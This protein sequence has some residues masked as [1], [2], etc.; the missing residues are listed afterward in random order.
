MAGSVA[1]AFDILARDRASSEINKVA[2]SFGHAAKAGAFLG[3]VAGSVVSKGL[4]LLGSAAQAAFAQVGSTISA[5]S[6]Y[7]ESLSKTRAVFGAASGSIEAFAKTT[8][9]GLGISQQE[10]LEAASTFGNLFTAMKIGVEPSAEMSK[11][12]VTLAGDLASFNNVGTDEA[13]ESLRSGLLGEAEPLRKFGVQLSD[14]RIQAEALA[15]GI[16]KPVANT[17][18]LQDAQTSLAVATERARL[19]L[20][21]HG[22]DSIEA[23]TAQQRVEAAARAVQAAVQ[24]QVPALTAAQKAQA[25]FNITLADTKAQQ[26]DAAR[27]G[28]EYAGQQ[29]RLE[30]A[31]K[32]LQVTIGTA[33]LPHMTDLTAWLNSEGL[34]AF[35]QFVDEMQNGTGRGG[36]F[37]ATMK[38]LGESAKE[39]ATTLKPMLEFLADHADTISKVAT[40]LEAMNFQLEIM[41]GYASVLGKVGDAIGYVG[42]KLGFGG[43][44]GDKPKPVTTVGDVALRDNRP[45]ASDD[46]KHDP[47]FQAVRAKS[48]AAAQEAATAAAK[49]ASTAYKAV[50]PTITPGLSDAIKKGEQAAVDAAEAVVDKI[51]DK[52]NEAKNKLGEI[53]QEALNF[54]EEIAKALTQGSGLADVF[55]TGTDLNAN[56]AFGGRG[57]DFERIKRFLEDRL[58]KIRQ[59]TQELRTLLARGLDQSLVAEIARAGVDA[60]HR[61]SAGLL[62][63][64]AAGIRDINHLTGAIGTVADS[65]GRVLE[66]QKFGELI[67][68]QRHQ[69]D[70]LHNDMARA[71]RHLHNISAAFDRKY[72]SA[73]SQRV[74]AFAAGAGGA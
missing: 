14:A 36:E 3:T 22:K 70:V 63:G 9:Q 40:G 30:K 4:G 65:T 18:R 20:A 19:A 26:G 35:T 16:V 53:V 47:K 41:S 56:G 60:G 51:R 72:G 66:Q 21:N 64:G 29:R 69:T 6:N 31:L 32:N 73:D 44:G 12:L 62:A 49:A 2:D 55:G 67:R 10:A 24:G 34:P 39:L 17:Q 48:V 8:T 52:F 5:A 27:T 50:L 15:S 45:A 11:R 13:L 28:D 42:D 46:P 58:R 7:N 59:F 57:G 74:A 43:G 61:I 71:E 37:A 33:L 25:A 23:V 68:A 54:R 38:D 1:L